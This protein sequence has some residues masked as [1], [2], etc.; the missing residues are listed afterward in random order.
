LT[1][2][3]G[4]NS[5]TCGNIGH[6]AKYCPRNQLRPEPI[7]AQNKGRKHKVQVKQ[8]RLNFTTLED[9]PEGVPVITGTFSILN[10]PT[11]ILFESVASHS[12][13]SAKFS[14]KCQLPFYH[15]K[16]AYM[17]ATPGGKVATCQLNH[18]VPIQF[19]NKIVKTTLLILGLESVDINLGTD[20]MIQ[21][22]AV[23]DVTNYAIEI[24][25]PTCG[26][27]TLYFPNQGSTRSCAFSMIELPF[28]NLQR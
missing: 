13:I 5:Y 17:I 25:S 11:I 9:L 1:P 4:A 24:Q 12:F 18:N 22:H 10:Q 28:E 27:L 16:G 8:G 23:I 15:T 7:V 3:K 26:E 6:Y 20:W 21:H 19:G 14:V 2:E